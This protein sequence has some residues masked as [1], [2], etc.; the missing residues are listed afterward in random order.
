WP[1]P[2]GT[3]GHQVSGIRCQLPENRRYLEF[4]SAIDDPTNGTKILDRRGQKERD[5]HRTYKGFNFFSAEDRGV[6]L[7]I[8]QG[9]NGITGFR[10][11]TPRRTDGTQ[12]AG[13]L[14]DPP[15]QST[16]VSD[17]IADT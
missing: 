9:E 13:A 4:I 6:L 7:A 5:A 16:A 1:E 3:P 12:T 2:N 14:R 17:L 10:P 15:P 11:R 8:V